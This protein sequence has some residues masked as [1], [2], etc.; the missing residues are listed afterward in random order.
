L[1]VAN[2]YDAAAKIMPVAITVLTKFIALRICTVGLC[3]G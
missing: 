3:R 2:M 1:Y